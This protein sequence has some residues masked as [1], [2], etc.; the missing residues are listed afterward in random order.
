MFLQVL[1]KRF[2]SSIDF[3]IERGK[4]ANWKILP[5][6]PTNVSFAVSSFTDHEF[7]FYSRNDETLII[8]SLNNK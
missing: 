8:I 4:G 1:F 3:P 7:L 2:Q 5:R 6:I